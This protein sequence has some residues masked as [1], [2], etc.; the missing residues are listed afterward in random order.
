MA[1]KRNSAPTT[2]IPALWIGILLCWVMAR[3]AGAETV[4]LNEPKIKGVYYESEVPD[5]L[6]L[7]ERAGLGLN[8]FT[9]SIREEL[10][11]EMVM[12][13]KGI[14]GVAMHV[15][16]LGCCQAKCMEA[17]AMQRLMCGS[18]QHLDREARMMEMMVGN[19]GPEGIWWVPRTSGRSW[20]GP[21]GHNPYANT[22]GQGRMLRAMIIWYQYTGDPRWRELIDRMVDG[23][24]KIFVVHKD[25]YAYV[26]THGFME[27]EYFRSCYVQGRGWKD[28][29][30]PS[31]EKS[32][33]EG[34]LLNHQANIAGPLA[35][36]YALTGN[37]QALRLSGEMI[38]FLMKPKFWA[39]FPGGEYPG[40]VGAEHAHWQGHFH[41]YVNA[42][43]SILDYAVVANDPRLKLLVRDGYEWSRQAQGALPTIGCVGD[44]QGCGIGRLIGL[45]VKLSEAG[46]GDYWEDVDQYIRNH[47]VEYQFTARDVLRMM[48]RPDLTAGEYD[49]PDDVLQKLGPDKLPSASGL[50]GI[51]TADVIRTAIGDVADRGDAIKGSS[52]QC[53]GSHGNMAFFYAWDGAL[54]QNE[55]VVRVNLLLN[56]AS[57]WLDLDSYLPYEGKVVLK[58]K[59]ARE[60][61]VRI[62]LWAE[63]KTVSCQVG[64]GPVNPQWFGRYLRFDNLKPDDVVTITF[65]V[66]ERTEKWTRLTRATT[67]GVSVLGKEGWSENT[68]TLRFKGNT[69]IEIKPSMSPLYDG[70]A[71]QF[72]LSRAPMRKCTRYVS[73]MVFAW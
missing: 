24:D 48:G 42:L 63:Q 37:K 43:R 2:C 73:P 57:P 58:N 27:E 18:R 45:A 36:W 32:G 12:G 26:P 46:V 10:N 39:D 70:R 64:V 3:G 16:G 19:I 59:K 40:V 22:H 62:P 11:Y 69:L 72:Q 66:V 20:L 54:H 34:S 47:A 8:H 31:D 52:W 9:E 13:I 61:F 65:P 51:T 25:D 50:P 23:M 28:T 41:G 55:G 38:R 67:E 1:M 33:E 5:T 56:R 71:E 53:C 17:M 60:A 49:L 30:E 35:T 4:A 21:E 44:G 15:T 6:D 14:N 7:A 68:C 29:T